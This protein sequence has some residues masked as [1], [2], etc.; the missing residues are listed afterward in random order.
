MSLKSITSGLTG[1]AWAV[2]KFDGIFVFHVIANRYYNPFLYD[3]HDRSVR[4]RGHD[5]AGYEGELQNFRPSFHTLGKVQIH[6]I[7]IEIG[8]VG[9]CHG[10]VQPE[11]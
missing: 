7:S 10:E 9:R 6:L 5:Q 3:S 4:L 8:I 2:L 1:N 11:G